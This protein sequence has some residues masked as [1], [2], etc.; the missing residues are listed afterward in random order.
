MKKEQKNSNFNQQNWSESE[1]LPNDFSAEQYLLTSVLVNQEMLEKV[2][3]ELPVKA[4]YYEPH[5]NL[6]I[7]IKILYQHDEQVNATNL[8]DLLQKEQKLE[9]VGGV[10]VLQ[11]LLNGFSNELYND[12]YFEIVRDKFLKRSLIKLGYETVNT[13]Y[14]ST[15]S[16]DKMLENLEERVESIRKAEG[17]KVYF[18][19]VK[20]LTDIFHKIKN[21]KG[22]T[23]L[24][25]LAT[26]FIELDKLTQGFQASDVIILAARPSVGKTALSLNIALNV[27]K[28]SHLPILFFS[29]E[30]SAEQ[31]M[32]RLLALET[33][34][35]FQKLKNG[36]IDGIEWQKIHIV[37]PILAKIPFFVDDSPNLSIQHIKERI[38]SIIRE[39][40][41][42]GMIIIDYLQLMG[43]SNTSE[44]RVQELSQITRSL[45]II[46]REFEIPILG[47][48]QLNRS[49][50][51][52]L[53]KKPLLS[54]LKESGSIEQDAD[55]VLML[56]KNASFQNDKSSIMQTLELSIVKHR[57]G[58]LGKLTLR[59]DGSRGKFLE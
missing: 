8:I 20:L 12:K 19:N 22:K 14:M 1:C 39:K 31:I 43:S 36:N 17:K 41:G 11:K 7:S 55:L 6:Y 21:Q 37:M 45:K 23:D 35:P 54:D 32:Y 4:F 48:S 5:Q 25:G 47:L 30:M 29:I 58:P 28:K 27:L 40:E 9:E 16:G 34:I 46:A 3:R 10:H 53:N 13:G 52:R 33:R 49:V 2:I 56:Y 18:N 50:E 57:N 24:P 59:F 42:L 38:K 15:I 51:T 44:N 26:G